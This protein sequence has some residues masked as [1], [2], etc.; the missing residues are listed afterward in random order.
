MHHWAIIGCELL[1]AQLSVAAVAPAYLEHWMH[2]LVN[3]RMSNKPN[4]FDG[5]ASLAAKLGQKNVLQ[6][7][8]DEGVTVSWQDF[9]WRNA[10]VRWISIFMYIHFY[11]FI[12]IYI[13]I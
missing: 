9:D 6:V 5:K 2:G 10:R 11:S 1:L 4:F 3:H 12:F 8:L 7:I 13:H